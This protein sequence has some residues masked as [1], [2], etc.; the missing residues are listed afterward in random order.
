[1]KAIVFDKLGLPTE[2]L[3]LREVSKPEP[4]AGEVLIKMLNAPI[5]PG[6]FLYIQN[7]YPEPKKPVLPGQ[8]A[9]N[10]G[11]GIVVGNGPGS[12]I[13]EGTLVVAYYFN[14]WAEYAVIPEK[15]LIP[16]PSDA[17]L[18]KAG[19]LMSLISAYDVVA[20]SKTKKGD[21]LA[22]TAG[23]SIVSIAAM[24]M[25][26]RRGIRV[27]ALVRKQPVGLDLRQ[28]GAEEV[29]DLSD[30]GGDTVEQRVRA[31]TAG[32]GLNGIIDS[33]GGP[34][35]ES[36]LHCTQPFAKVI[37]YG[38]MDERSFKAHN[39]EILMKGLIIE[40]YIYR[41]FF[42]PPVPEEK[43]MI[44]EIVDMTKDPSFIVPVSG[45]YRLDEHQT[46]IQKSFYSTAGSTTGKG[47]F[48]IA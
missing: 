23:N 11:T 42:T 41:H 47:L 19:Q 35:L 31:L 28:L 44:R 34:L 36:L 32:A 39:I 4:G 46:A 37:I 14:T 12:K 43:E 27:I 1:M 21:W 15:W 18:E 48:I 10:S 7:L 6:D 25:A 22:V 5:N 20:A 8:V 45:R 24:Q 40:A 9:G 3:Q 33:V 13:A 38:N 30:L 16:L 2:V 26:R 29:I 17:P